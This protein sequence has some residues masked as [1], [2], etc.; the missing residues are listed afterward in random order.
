MRV[1]L[2]IGEPGTFYHMILTYIIAHGQDHS[3]DC[4]TPLPFAGDNVS[5]LSLWYK[6]A[7]KSSYKK[8][9]FAAFLCHLRTTCTAVLA[10]AKF[11]FLPSF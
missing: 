1:S 4:C 5:V 3:K 11:T 8:C 9:R 2:G 6:W 10:H 7:L